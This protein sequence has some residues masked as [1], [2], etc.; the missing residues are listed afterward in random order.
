MEQHKRTHLVNLLMEEATLMQ[1][2]LEKAMEGQRT[3]ERQQTLHGVHHAHGEYSLQDEH[4]AWEK[5]V[6]ALHGIQTE[7]DQIA[8]AERQRVER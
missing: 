1:G 2:V 8:G 6:Q 7:L 5:I 4:A 3:E